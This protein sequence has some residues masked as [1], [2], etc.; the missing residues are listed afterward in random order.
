MLVEEDY[1]GDL[2]E[3][4]I[5]VVADVVSPPKEPTVSAVADGLWPIIAA[6]H[7]HASI[8]SLAGVDNGGTRGS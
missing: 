4:T 1:L 3:S 8:A 7:T 5:S 2:D 6:S